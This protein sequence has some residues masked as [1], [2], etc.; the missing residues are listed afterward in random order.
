MMNQFNGAR[1]MSR[2]IKTMKPIKTNVG[3]TMSKSLKMSVVFAGIL[4]TGCASYQK[5]HFTVGST[6]KDYRTQHPIVVSQAEVSEDLIVSRSMS[7]MSFRHENTATSFYG[8]FKQSGARTLNVM[9]PAG[10]HNESAA[11]K[12]AHDVIAHMKDLG[13]EAH[14]VSVSRYHASNHGDAAT[15]R[16]SYGAITADVASKCGQ[17]NEDLGQT[18]EN[19]NYNNFGCSTQNNLAKMIANPADLLGPRGESEIDA[20]RRDNV[21]N[22]WRENGTASLPSLL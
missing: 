11:R 17:W 16:L 21:I 13:L 9:L 8:K 4:L 7:K 18:S 12:V 22:D 5:D 3:T 10:S 19:Q 2:V 15:V 14:Q 20:G 1:K 6:P